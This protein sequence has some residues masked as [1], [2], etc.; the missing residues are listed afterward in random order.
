MNLRSLAKQAARPV[1]QRAT[2]G[3]LVWRGP[4]TPRRIALTFDDGPHQLTPR[5]LELLADHGV[6]ATFFVMG[7]WID[8]RPAIVNDYLRGGHQLAGHGYYHKRF[9][10]LRPLALRDE[11]A[12]MSRA[13]GRMPHGAWVRPPHGTIGALDVST[14]IA[15][16]Y[17]VALWS[18]DSLDH[19]GSTA[20][21]IA[22]R[23]RPEVVRPGEV[24]LFHEG[25]DTT[26]AALPTIIDRLHADGYELVTMADLIAP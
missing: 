7:A 19:D 9:T 2:G 21:V 26:L 15:S 14:M 3:R 13:I 20:E 12:S 10:E 18:H 6:P 17:V 1:L 24:I 22:H 11:L 8:E 25:Q 5:M 23:C 4:A 16:G